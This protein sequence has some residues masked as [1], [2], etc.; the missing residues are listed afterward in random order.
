LIADLVIWPEYAS[1]AVEDG[2]T[3]GLSA[4]YAFVADMTPTVWHGE[5]ADGV[6]RDITANHVAIVSEPRVP[7]ALVADSAFNR[8][9]NHQMRH[10]NTFRGIYLAADAA[11]RRRR[12]RDAEPTEGELDN[13]D[14]T[15]EDLLAIVEDWLVDMDPQDAEKLL[16]GLLELKANHE[17]EQAVDR[18]HTASRAHTATRAHRAGDRHRLAGDALPGI[19]P[20]HERFKNLG[21][22]TVMG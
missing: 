17:N 7:D 19:R 8:G 11:I 2:T 10:H 9:S 20:A 14:A 15:P 6:M 4:G 1:R 5:R 21:R 3:P 13:E 12:A 18:A 16:D 22:I